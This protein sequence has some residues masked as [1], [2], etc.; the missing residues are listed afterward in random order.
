M[1]SL[2]FTYFSLFLMTASSSFPSSELTTL[3]LPSV[4]LSFS[5]YQLIS[6]AQTLFPVTLV[7]EKCLVSAPSLLSQSKIVLQVT[8]PPQYYHGFHLFSVI[9]KLMHL[10]AESFYLL[11]Q[12]PCSVLLYAESFFSLRSAL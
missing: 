10:S 9:L 1:I 11:H 4:S 8:L 2:K 12:P 3:T 6:Q 7:I 5:R